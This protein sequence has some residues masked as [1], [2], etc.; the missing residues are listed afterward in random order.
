[1]DAMHVMTVM[2]LVLAIGVWLGW[3]AR[4]EEEERIRRADDD[5]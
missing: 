3:T 1:M 5:R 4:G 2:T